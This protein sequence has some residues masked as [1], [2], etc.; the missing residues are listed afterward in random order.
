[1]KK[2][3]KNLAAAI[4]LAG[5]VL[6]AQ[7]TIYTTTFSTSSLEDDDE[8]GNNSDDLTILA[9]GNFATLAFN[10]NTNTFTVTAAS[11]DT[12]FGAG[13]YIDA[14]LFETN[15][16]LGEISP[17]TVTQPAYSTDDIT[18][19]AEF[20]SDLPNFTDG[21]GG[22]PN[23]DVGYSFNNPLHDNQQVTFVVNGFNP[24]CLTAN[25]GCGVN[26]NL[27]SQNAFALRVRNG[28]DDT[29]EVSYFLGAS[30]DPASAVPEPETYAMFMAGLGLLGFVSRRKKSV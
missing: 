24:N 9:A 20:S 8:F 16:S 30:I 1:M 3:Y 28:T 2:A 21:P 6:P 5:M 18:S 27:L 13:Y 4:L 17:G 25:T 10:S 14:V 15:Q 19:I 11:L 29:N 7:A 12:F 23:F 22:I 26:S